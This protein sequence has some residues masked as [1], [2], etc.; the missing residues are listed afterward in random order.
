MSLYDVAII[1]GGPSGLAAATYTTG[2]Q[3]STVILAPDLGGKVNYEFRLRDQAKSTPI[4][5][6]ET[7]HV[8]EKNVKAEQVEHKTTQ[9]S[10]VAKTEDGTFRIALETGDDVLA[11]AVIVATGAKPQRLYTPGEQ[12]YWGKGLSF[13]AIS[14]APF[15]VD[16][17]VAVVGNTERTQIAIL[18]LA[19]VAKHIFWISSTTHEAS[20]EKLRQLENHP[21]VTPMYGW[22]VQRVLGDEYVS[23]VEIAAGY[24]IRELP[25]DGVFVEMGLIPN[26][27]FVRGLIDFDPETGHIPVNQ[28]CETAL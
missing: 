12:E 14:H 23:A 4:W 11:R 25:V 3:L 10:Q 9:V 24:T 22:E 19:T 18:Q 5:G 15:F 2:F 20:D 16:R 28:R 17:T 13:S 27:E 1:G 6:L 8:F 26:I 7:V 21:K